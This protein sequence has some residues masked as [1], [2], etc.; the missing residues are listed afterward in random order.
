MTDR[1]SVYVVWKKGMQTAGSLGREHEQENKKIGPQT[2]KKKQKW[3][4]LED[5]K[6]AAGRWAL[7][8]MRTKQTE[9]KEMTVIGV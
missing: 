6:H 8:E 3:F 4:Y 2:V 5:R 7:N 1:S 9:M